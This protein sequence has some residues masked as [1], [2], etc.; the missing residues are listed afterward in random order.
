VN[1]PTTEE[2]RSYLLRRLSETARTRFEE[3]YF[4]D[5]ALLDRIEEEEDRLVSDYVLGRLSQTDRQKFEQSLLG[6]PYYRER[7]ETTRGLKLR[8]DGHR[9]LSRPAS[10]APAGRERLFPGRTGTLVAFALLSLLLVAALVSAARLKSE[11]NEVRRTRAATPSPPAPSVQAGIIPIARTV[12]L[13]PD[14]SAGP[15]L[16][17]LERPPGAAVLLVV[18][19]GLLPPEARGWEVVLSDGAAVRWA[20]GPQPPR[21]PDD[22]D[23]ALRLPPGV[24]PA[25]R[26]GVSL[27]SGSDGASVERFVGV[28]EIA[29][30]RL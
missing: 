14:P 9:W 7:V 25:G 6:T 5:D 15:A 24:P 4:S 11:L 12:A 27:R 10:H 22:G 3:A 8:L 2:I 20:S 28:L 19:R 23:L 26:F 29:D 30:G 17:R 21:T 18:P 1:E 16:F 13:E